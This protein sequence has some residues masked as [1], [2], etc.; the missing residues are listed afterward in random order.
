MKV[1]VVDVGG[2]HVKILATGQEEMREMP[3]GLMLTAQAMVD[4]VRKLAAGW[5]YDVVS[6]GY[7]GPVV[8]GLPRLEPHNLGKGWV[9]FDYAAAFEH[10]VKLVNDAAMQ[11]LGSYEGGSMLFLGLGTGLGSALIY[12]G[13]LEPLEFAHLPYK[14]GRSYEDYLGIRGLKRLGKKRW[15][16]AVAD[17]VE[18][19]LAAFEVDYIVL[20]GGNSKKITT[21]PE[22]ARLAPTPTRSSAG[23]A[24]G[25]IP[26]TTIKITSNDRLPG[27]DMLRLGPWQLETVNGG[28]FWLDAGVMYG[29]IPKTVWQGVTPPDEQNRIPVGI[30]CVLARNGE[31]TVLI[32]TGHGDKLSPLDRSAHAIERTPTLLDSLSALG[33]EAGDVDLVVLS[34]L[35]W[36]HAGGATML[37]EN[38]RCQPTFP[39]A[40]YFVSR[41]EWEDAISGAPEL[42]GSYAAENF[43]PAQRIGAVGACRR[44]SGDCTRIVD[45]ADRR[46]YAWA[47]GS[48]VRIGG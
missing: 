23:F 35:H 27:N 44:R 37:G 28:R 5:Q 30:H 18:K 1:L 22:G 16:R 46:P 33:V 13:V 12:D 32:D 43:G 48:A 19:L 45:A 26:K 38:R 11:A 10:P 34:H 7:P 17:V 20:G 47:P 2:T 24:C 15:R 8:R 14:K 42:A 21:V 41:L 4:G 39:S 31:Q 6:I 3:S 40:T 9:G 25:K 29:I 36:D